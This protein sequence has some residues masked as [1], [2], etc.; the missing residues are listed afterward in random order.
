MRVLVTDDEPLI[1]QG[2]R[3][4]IENAL[5]QAE[6]AAFPGG[7]QALDWC[8]TH[9][10]D[11][12]FLDIEM[13]GMN[14]LELA[15]TLQE[16]HPDVNVIFTTCYPD[17]A[18]DSYRLRASGYLMKPV[19]EEDVRREVENLRHRPEPR[20]QEGLCLRAFGSFAALKDGKPLLFRYQKTLELLAYLTDRNGAWCTN[21][22]LRGALWE[23][24][25]GCQQAESYLRQLKKDLTDT[26]KEAGCQDVIL[27][28]R[29]RLCL[30]PDRVR[31]DYYDFLSGRAEDRKMY[32]G[33]YMT[34]YSW[35]ETTHAWLEQEG[36]P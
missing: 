26:L 1:L 33:E 32:Q 2:L 9:P 31:C 36:R 5:P 20:K 19:S 8:R 17:Y 35:A 15:R 30:L 24:R 12:A 3:K 28:R 14:G 21:G 25:S 6:V 27:A 34:Q 29:G 11:V 13:R 7:E 4:T 18:L 22:E 10:L 23:D 16:L